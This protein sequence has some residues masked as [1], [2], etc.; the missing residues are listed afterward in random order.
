MKAYE[1]TAGNVVLGMGLTGLILLLGA[2]RVPGQNALSAGP[3]DAARLRIMTSFYPIYIATL[4]V[5]NDIPGVEV[6]NLTQPQTGCLHDYQMTP[7]DLIQ[8]SAADIFVVNGAGMEAF[9]DK[10]ARQRPTLTVVTASEGI[11]LIKGAG[12]E[13]DNAHVWVSVALHIQQVRNIAVQLA[14]ADRPHADGY[15]KNAATYIARLETLRT[16]M[17]EGLKDIQTRDMITFHE[18]FPYFAKEFGLNVVAV[19]A[20]EPGSEPSAK[21]LADTIEIVRRASTKALFAEPQYPSR[22]A[23]AIARETGAPV[24]TLDPVVT[25]PMK[26]DAYLEIMERNLAQ[27]QKALKRP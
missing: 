27:L 23:E 19:I 7:A 14:K 11:D 26:A 4:N 21:Q 15:R 5:V 10:V 25:G 9:L 1:K 2:A 8:L 13:G 24:Y 20:R 6:R 17:H 22:A 3:V 16:K 12:E 18:A